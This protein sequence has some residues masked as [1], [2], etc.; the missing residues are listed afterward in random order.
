MSQIV[1][2]EIAQEAGYAA[3]FVTLAI[4]GCFAWTCIFLVKETGG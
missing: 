3:M 2:G 4:F 1:A